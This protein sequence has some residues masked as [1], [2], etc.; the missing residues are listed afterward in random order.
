MAERF[1]APCGG[2]KHKKYLRVNS[3]LAQ[4]PKISKD[5]H[6]LEELRK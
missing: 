1:L 2:D 5:E 4:A 3:L 6:P